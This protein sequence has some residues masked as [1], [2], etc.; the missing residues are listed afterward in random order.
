[1]SL[2]RL[3]IF[4]HWLGTPFRAIV[5]LDF[6]Q[7]RSLFSIAMLCGVV[8]L[9][10]ENW[11]L[12]ALAHHSIENGEAAA[13]WIGLLLER[14]RYNSGLQAWFSFILGLVVFGAE[15]FRAKW[16]ENE[17]GAGRGADVSGDV[18]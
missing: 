6:R 9:S 15:Y 5:A 8:A 10:A 16:G 7:V 17:I 3:G 1:M 12:V 14:L 18:P 4:W 13:A 2:R 11:A